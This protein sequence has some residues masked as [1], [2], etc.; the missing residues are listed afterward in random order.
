[1]IVASELKMLLLDTCLF[2]SIFLL[3]SIGS[4][5]A[6]AVVGLGPLSSLPAPLYRA[7][8]LDQ[9]E[10]SKNP[11]ANY[12]MMKQ[13]PQP[14][15]YVILTHLEHI[16]NMRNSRPEEH[17]QQYKIIRYTP[18]KKVSTR[19]NKV[20]SSMVPT[21][22]NIEENVLGWTP[23]SSRSLADRQPVDEEKGERYFNSTT[24]QASCLWASDNIQSSKISLSMLNLQKAYSTK[25]LTFIMFFLL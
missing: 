13:Q 12:D 15:K 7:L 5:Q 3:I 11:P 1:M 8:Y 14:V 23:W 16:T 22:T 25:I 10:H 6:R 21:K 9:E 18:S 2:S 4:V 24:W 20:S 19:A 17:N